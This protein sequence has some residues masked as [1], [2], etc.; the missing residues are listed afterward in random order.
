[1]DFAPE[2]F[3]KLG[4]FPLLVFSLQGALLKITNGLL[5]LGAWMPCKTVV[6]RGHTAILFNRMKMGG[7]RWV[8]ASWA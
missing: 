7:C 5:L 4:H 3:C 1:M 8:A 2:M 6:F